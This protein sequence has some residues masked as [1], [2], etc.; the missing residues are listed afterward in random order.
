MGY[1][2][3]DLAFC[4]HVGSPASPVAYYQQ[5]GRAGRALD[6]AL[7]VL[8]PAETDEQIWARANDASN[9]IGNLILHLAGSSRHWAVE[10]IGGT[11][12]GRPLRSMATNV[13]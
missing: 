11:S 9:S 7:A 12:I 4:I 3:P 6:D 5:V 8:L 2:K 10:V 1:D 13:R